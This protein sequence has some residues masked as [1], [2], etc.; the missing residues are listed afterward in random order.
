LA[1]YVSNL[2]GSVDDPHVEISIPTQKK[3]AKL[4]AQFHLEMEEIIDVSCEIS[5]FLYDPGFKDNIKNLPELLRKTLTNYA[6]QSVSL[7]RGWLS[8][9]LI[10]LKRNTERSPEKIE[11]HNLRRLQDPTPYAVALKAMLSQRHIYYPP[12]NV[13]PD[14]PLFGSAKTEATAS[15]DQL[16]QELK[17]IVATVLRAETSVIDIDKPFAEL[18]MDS[19][20]GIETMMAIN[21]KYGMELS[22][23]Q[24]LDHPTLREFALF[25]EQE[26]KSGGGSSDN[27]PSEPTEAVASPDQLQQE[28]KT[29]LATVLRAE[30]SVI[31]IDKPFAE[32]GMDSVTGIETMMAIN[33]EYGMELSNIK[34]L[35]H[36]T[37][38][39]LA[40]F[41]Q[42]ET[43]NIEIS[44]EQILP[45][46]VAT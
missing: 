31:D 22:N 18:G 15:L 9:V 23:I 1:D 6:N 8:Y 33:K 13:L 11:S 4:T 26:M 21:K 44:D 38:R 41:L 7:E 5:N 34:L 37:V 10:K 14:G 29:I 25:L 28:L 16:Q 30:I 43:K 46:P 2:P 40:Q 20:T 19:V 36:P 24:L 32:L 17:T 42:Q 39:E 12:R 27:P 45:R 35:D 3:W